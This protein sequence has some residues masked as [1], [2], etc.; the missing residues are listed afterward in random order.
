M[1]RRPAS[2]RSLA[3]ATVPILMSQENRIWFANNPWPE[4]HLIKEF[5][6]TAEI[7]DGLVWMSIH[8]ESADYYSE[9]EIDDDGVEYDSDWQAPIVWA[10]YHSCTMSCTEW[11]HGGWAVCPVEKFSLEFL[12]GYEA[13]VDPLPDS[14][15]T[16]FDDLAFNIYLL[17]H[18]AVAGHKIRF[19]RQGG[20]DR[21]EIEWS[22][23]IANAYV[24]NYNYR[25]DFRAVIFG[26]PAPQLTLLA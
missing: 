7:R 8:L 21:F 2:L 14:A 22:G 11:H 17:G 24:G 20:S 25:H 9:R 4:G 19:T 6:W 16:D 26:I 3:Q 5:Q 15:E 13:S 18:D 10:N 23:K 1:H 12:N